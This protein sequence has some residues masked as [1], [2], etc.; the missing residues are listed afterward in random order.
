M[1]TVEK[2]DV[3]SRKRLIGS[4]KAPDAGKTVW[5]ARVFGTCVGVKTGDGDK[6]PWTRYIGDFIAKTLVAVGR[7]QQIRAVRA[8]MMYLP[9][10]A[11]TLM[12]AAGIDEENEGQFNDFGLQIG[13]ASDD[14]GRPSY[15]AEWI[16]TPEP[17]SPAEALVAKHAPDML[18]DAEAPPKAAPASPKKK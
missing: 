11:M 6:G 1:S 2:V 12:A 5:L 8:G 7:D 16:V 3:I 14:K 18:G 17:S 13:I 4:A 9:E 15:V 10:A